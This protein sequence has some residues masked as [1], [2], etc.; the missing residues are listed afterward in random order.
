MQ[1]SVCEDIKKH[2]DGD[3]KTEI[4]VARVF[5]TQNWS[6]VS[7][8]VCQNQMIFFFNWI[9]AHLVRNDA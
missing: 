7:N 2:H 5:L 8:F 3:N 1:N 9:T 4:K 6:S